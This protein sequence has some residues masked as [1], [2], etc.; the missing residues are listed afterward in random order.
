MSVSVLAI[1]FFLCADG[2]WHFM[3]CFEVLNI[4]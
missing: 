1:Q 2:Q 4:N 3:L